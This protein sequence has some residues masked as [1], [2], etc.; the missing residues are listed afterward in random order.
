MSRFHNRTPS[1]FPCN[2]KLPYAPVVKY[3]KIFHK[4]GCL[5][6]FITLFYSLQI[7]QRQY[8]TQNISALPFRKLLRISEIWM[9]KY[10]TEFSQ[11]VNRH[12]IFIRP[13]AGESPACA[14]ICSST[15]PSSHL[16][17]LSICEILLHK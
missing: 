5:C 6:H 1:T 16:S 12:F 11:I 8:R 14:I 17:F 3:V 2:Q 15:A 7:F 10:N 4:Q 13:A 9:F